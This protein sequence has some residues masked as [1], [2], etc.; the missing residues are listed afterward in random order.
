MACRMD[1]LFSIF[2]HHGG[3]F[4]KNHK[5]YVRG[6]V[7]LVDNC[8]PDKW[9]KVEIEGICRNFG[10]TFVSKLWYAMPGM[11]KE[12][13]NFHLVDDDDVMYMTELVKGHEEIHVY[14]EQPI[15]DHILVDE[16]KNVSEGVQP[17]AVEQGLM[18]YYSDY[19][20]ESDDDDHDGG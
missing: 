12:R 2:V 5:K 4:T 16:G 17:L 14:V 6:E 15:D 11:E 9:S 1:D 7:D 3:Y 18:G 13:E 19:N 20:D 10:Y 8:D